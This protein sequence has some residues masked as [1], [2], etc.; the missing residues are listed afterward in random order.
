MLKLIIMALFVLSLNA[1]MIKVRAVEQ[2]PTKQEAIQNAYW[3][4]FEQALDKILGASSY[5]GNV[6]D[7]FKSDFRKDF[8]NF[9]ET[10]FRNPRYKC[11]NLKQDGYECLVVSNLNLDQIRAIVSEKSNSTTT[12]GRNGVQSLD[13]VLI[14]EVNSDLS[15][16]FITNLQ[17]SINDS[18]NSLRV[19]KKGTQVGVKGNKCEDLREKYIKYKR[20]GPAFKS[21]VRAINKKLK[22]CKENKSV[23]YLFKLTKLKFSTLGKDSY[24][25][26]TGSLIYRM[27]MINTKTGRVDNAIRSKDVES[28]GENIDQLK[29]RLYKKAADVA[30]R[31]IVNN[32]LKSLRKK[33]RIKKMAKVK[34]YEF[35]YTIILNGVTYDSKNRDKI[36]MIKSVVK[37]LGARA[38][39]NSKE[40]SDF[41][42]VYNFG[43]NSEIDPD[44]LTFDLYDRAKKLGYKIQIEDKGDNIIVVKF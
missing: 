36:K 9:R 42:Q 1:N 14:D 27:S 11:N 35:L 23:N 39:R 8:L 40:S 4:I 24:N 5:V 10:Y 29:F 16:D 20:K 3:V 25:N 19:E 6:K 22:E 43:T 37:N 26:T 28:F 34:K 41:E 31:E 7:S 13:I 15:R 18:G 30:T 2:A 21:A 12:M 32:I 17:S 44:D 38:R 33:S